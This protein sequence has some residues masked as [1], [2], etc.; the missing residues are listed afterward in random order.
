[1]FNPFSTIEWFYLVYFF[2]G[3]AFLVMGLS[4]TITNMKESNLRL[5]DSLW[6]LG[7]F[8]FTHG[9][10]EW[11]QVYPLI[12]GDHLTLSQIFAVKSISL[13]LLIVSFL[14]LLKFGVSL[15]SDMK[16][17]RPLWLM[18]IPAALF[19]I[20]AIFVVSES[21]VMRMQVLHQIGTAARDTLGLTGGL[22]TAWGLVLCARETKALSRPISR[23]FLYAGIAFASYSVFVS[24]IFADI[25]YD[26]F[27]LPKEIFRGTAAI[28]ITYFII[29]ALNIF[30][31]DMRK[32]VEKQSR[33]LV[34]AE[35]L[36]SLGQL[37][38]GI[39][40]EINNPLTNASLGIQTLR[41]KLNGSGMGQEVAERLNAVEKNI[42]RASTIAQE[43]LEFSR[44]KES[45]FISLNINN[46]I[47]SSLILMKHK[48]GSV[49]VR[50][51]LATVPEIMGDRGKLEQVFINIISN[52]L[53]SMPEGGALSISTLTGKDA[54]EARISDTG[55]GIAEEN[56]SRVFDPFFTTKEVGSG[57]GLG[58]SI[59][60]G[61]IKQHRGTIELSSAVGKGTTVV[62]KIPIESKEP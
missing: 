26:Y 62:I 55:T 17:V 14:F 49:E 44:Q 8:G 39:A 4:I 20:W 22:M 56:I 11:L 35:K 28:L 5:A 27:P 54:I 21:A 45:R 34:Q 42:D 31:V 2:Y 43:L 19:S 61:I 60:Y 1:M 50:R 53:E 9:A 6:L 38:A 7:M 15:V 37:A 3:A 33:H 12:A 29:K 48:L 58:L 32:Q 36:A 30:N 40:H 47:E 52:A 59:C 24:S 18:G 23:H 46:V 10:R 51:D 13:V 16:R 57:T 41:S 25:A